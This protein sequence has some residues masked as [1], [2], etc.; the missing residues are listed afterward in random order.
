VLCGA[1]VDDAAVE[2]INQVAP[3]PPQQAVRAVA[4]G[5]ERRK[6]PALWELAP[7][8]DGGELGQVV[9]RGVDAGSS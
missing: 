3:K 2:A 7:G 8:G 6:L 5:P 1:G 9:L 4:V